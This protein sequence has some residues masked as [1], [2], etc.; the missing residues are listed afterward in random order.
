MTKVHKTDAKGARAVKQAQSRYTVV[1]RLNRSLHKQGAVVLV[2]MS[3][4]G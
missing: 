2:L 1:A 3:Y 4:K